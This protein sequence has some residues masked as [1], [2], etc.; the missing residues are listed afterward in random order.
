MFINITTD[1]AGGPV[2][3]GGNATNSFSTWLSSADTIDNDQP[4]VI[5]NNGGML[6]LCAPDATAYVVTAASGDIL[7]LTN[8]SG[9]STATYKIAIWGASA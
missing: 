4:C 9:A 1:T 3:V 8:T 2:K 6:Y 5:V 7:K